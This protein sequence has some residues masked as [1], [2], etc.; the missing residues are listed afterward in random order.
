MQNS[1]SEPVSKTSV[2]LSSEEMNSEIEKWKC[3]ILNGVVGM[4]R[5]ICM[6]VTKYFKNDSDI[7]EVC[8]FF[9]F[10]FDFIFCFYFD[11]SLFALIPNS[12]SGSDISCLKIFEVYVNFLFIFF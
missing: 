7:I 11:Y 9:I 8:F 3:N 4:L 5:D 6:R 2:L 10:V 12:S 1:N